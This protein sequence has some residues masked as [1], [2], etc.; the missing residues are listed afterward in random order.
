LA[1]EP[2]FVDESAYYSQSYF[3][4]LYASCRWGDPAWLTYP[5]YDLPPLPKYLIG[6]ALAVARYPTPTPADAAR[7]YADTSIR[8]DPPGALTAARIPS[9]FVGVV[10]C[11]A[12]Y[13]LGVLVGGRSVGVAAAGLLMINPLYRLLSRRAMSDAPCEA[14]LQLGLFLSLMAWR[15]TVAGRGAAEGW[16]SFV[17]AGAAAGL[18]LL[19]KMSGVLIGPIGAVWTVLA[20]A[21]PG[22]VAKAARFATGMAAAGLVAC[23]VFTVLDPYLVARPARVSNPALMGVASSSVVERVRALFRLRFQVSAD[24]QRMFPHNATIALSD[25]LATTA[26]QGFG[27]FGPFGPAHSD[28]TK[29]YDR[30]QDWGAVLWLPWIAGGAV[31]AARRGLE[32]RRA[33]EPPTAWAVL[34]Q[35]AATLAVVALYLPM[36]WDRYF[37]PLQAPACLLAAGGACAATRRIAI[38]VRG[39]P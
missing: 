31:W 17:G 18:S 15:R 6:A 9:V 26:V 22:S 14:F 38:A 8:F 39:R 21:S 19:S 25:K 28:S 11:L 16:V 34:G 30:A 32:Q 36:A 29:R 4:R 13:G 5:A 10:G 20:V 3:A 33:G 2:H 35:F 7:W 12:V 24:Q 27:R 37:L 23:C 1:D